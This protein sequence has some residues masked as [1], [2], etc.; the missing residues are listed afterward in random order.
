MTTTRL[1]PGTSTPCDPP[2]PPVPGSTRSRAWGDALD[3]CDGDG[4]TPIDRCGGDPWIVALYR[5][6]VVAGAVFLLVATLASLGLWPT[7]GL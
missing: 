7:R 3:I 1:T 6:C 4:D 2:S 5:V